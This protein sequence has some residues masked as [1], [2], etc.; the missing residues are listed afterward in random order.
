MN[1][2]LPGD[3]AAHPATDTSATDMVADPRARPADEQIIPIAEETFKVETHE[4]V[5]GRVRVRTFAETVEELAR[6]ELGRESVE[7]TRVPVGRP[8]EV[9]PEIRH[10]GDLTI[11]P[12]LEE[13]LVVEKR[14][15]LKEE[16][17]VQRRRTTE[18]VEVPVELRKERVEIE[19]IPVADRRTSKD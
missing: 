2:R 7:V 4:V 3:D 16:L 10:E 11:I 19:R 13:V 17:H 6:A 5:T 15:I 14:L 9:A 1:R 12:V 8:V 18:E